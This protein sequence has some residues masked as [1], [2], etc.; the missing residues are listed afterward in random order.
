MEAR[1]LRV[2]DAWRAGG[3]QDERDEFLEERPK[4][5]LER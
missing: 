4:V 1:D 3:F 5:D 2:E